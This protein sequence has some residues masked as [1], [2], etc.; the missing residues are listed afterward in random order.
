MHLASEFEITA[1][2]AAKSTLGLYV[3][4]PNGRLSYAVFP[5]PELR[6]KIDYEEVIVVKPDNSEA[7][8]DIGITDGKT[9]SFGLV[10]SAL[11]DREFANTCMATVTTNGP[12]MIRLTVQMADDPNVILAWDAKKPA[13]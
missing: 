9:G 8:Y 12:S 10:I 3:A 5:M 4:D 13:S 11:C 2:L 7:V 1:I 6:Q